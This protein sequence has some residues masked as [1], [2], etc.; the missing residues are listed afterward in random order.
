MAG[1]LTCP[2]VLGADLM[3]AYNFTAGI[4][5]FDAAAA[6]AGLGAHVLDN[7]HAAVLVA[8]QVSGS[9]DMSFPSDYTQYNAVRFFAAAHE[10]TAFDHSS[11][12]TPSTAITH[13]SHIELYLSQSKHSTYFV[14]PNSTPILISEAGLEYIEEILLPVLNTSIGF[15]YY[16]ICPYDD[17][18]LVVGPDGTIYFIIDNG[19]GSCYVP[20]ISV[21][22]YDLALEEVFIDEVLRDCTG[23]HFIEQGISYAQ[24]RINVGEVA[25]PTAGNHFI[26]DATPDYAGTKITESLFADVQL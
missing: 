12:Y 8:V 24:N 11:Y 17:S 20:D 25:N 10:H 5:G 18:Y 16:G 2:A 3:F 4:I 14:N 13:D 1:S 9:N 22:Y 21:D 6:S 26:Q 23:E 15:Y 7:E 19:D